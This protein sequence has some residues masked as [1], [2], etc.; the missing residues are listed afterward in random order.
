MLPPGHALLELFTTVQVHKTGLMTPDLQVGVR[1][2]CLRALMI[3]SCAHR[4]PRACLTVSEYDSTP[5]SAARWTKCRTA[6]A[7]TTFELPISFR[8]AA[9]IATAVFTPETESRTFRASKWLWLWLWLWLR[10]RLCLCMR[11]SVSDRITHISG[12]NV[13]EYPVGKILEEIVGPCASMLDLTVVREASDRVG[14]GKLCKYMRIFCQL[15]A[16]DQGVRKRGPSTRWR[17]KNTLAKCVLLPEAMSL[18]R[19]HTHTQM[20]DADAREPRLRF[21]LS[22]ARQSTGTSWT[23]YVRL[24]SK[25]RSVTLKSRA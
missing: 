23:G 9:C 18:T 5:A 14:A 12:K 10:P 2:H 3:S 1:C 8:T 7:T 19:A 4:K 13:E 6:T 24:R 20:H 21:Q 16:Q 11:V 17:E 15:G 25:C 22:A